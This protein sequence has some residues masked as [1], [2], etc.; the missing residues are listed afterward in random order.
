M[1]ES[2]LYEAL[3]KIQDDAVAAEQERTFSGRLDALREQMPR[4]EI[5]RDQAAAF[6]DRYNI[7]EQAREIASL[8]M[9]QKI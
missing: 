8:V 7:R 6:V 9:P 1:R 3:R 4:M 5:P 2:S